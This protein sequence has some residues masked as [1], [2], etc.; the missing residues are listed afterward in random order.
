MDAPIPKSERKK[1]IPTLEIEKVYWAQGIHDI[2][3][4]DEAGRGPLAGPVV[5][6]AVILPEGITIPGVNDSKKLSARQREELFHEIHSVALCIG[7][8]I[9]SH[10]VI[11]RINIY[12]ASILAMRKA[13]ENLSVVP[14]FLL[15]DGNSFRHETLR[16]QNV[17]A[18]DAR[19]VTIAAASIIA[20]VTRDSLM[21]E[22]HEQFPQYGFDRHKGY[23]TKVHV[24]ALRLHGLCPIHRR[25]FHI[26]YETGHSAD[27]GPAS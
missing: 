22:Y 26:P 21:C 11:D 27:G 14:G 2:A 24:E 18:G 19:S 13:V 6:G 4:V 10:E 7:V 9:V 8:G 16:Y 1:L 23:G 20:K 15:A 25:S 3:G 5:A 17:V 12:Q